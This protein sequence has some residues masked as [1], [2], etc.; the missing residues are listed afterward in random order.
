MYIKKAKGAKK[1]QYEESVSVPQWDVNYIRIN[2]IF[3]CFSV[4][5][6]RES[7]SVEDNN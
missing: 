5:S 4:C 3:E 1:K 2:L 6:I 7:F